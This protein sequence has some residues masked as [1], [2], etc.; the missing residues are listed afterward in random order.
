MSSGTSGLIEAAAELVSAATIL[1]AYASGCL[2]F[3]SSR[4]DGWPSCC[5]G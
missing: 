2:W 4:G 5:H 3:F 1:R